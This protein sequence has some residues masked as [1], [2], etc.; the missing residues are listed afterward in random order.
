MNGQQMLKRDFVG[1]LTPREGQT[2]RAT[3]L[4]A[5]QAAKSPLTL[6]TIGAASLIALACQLVAPLVAVP[7]I[8]GMLFIVRLRSAR[9]WR[10]AERE[11]HHSPIELPDLIWYSDAGAQV[12]IRRLAQARRAL[13][14]AVAQSPL[15]PENEILARLRSVAD[16]ERRIVLLTAR[17]EY[18][19][20]FLTEISLA[21]IEAE[22]L[23]IRV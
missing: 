3:A 20:K 18:L 21:E 11:A 7:V 5:K 4:A 9:T 16:I 22:V 13:A 23:R 6:A 14:K 8:F 12:A 1:D 10:T 17:V 15:D 2:G 19:G